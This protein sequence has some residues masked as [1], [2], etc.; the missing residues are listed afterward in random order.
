[1]WG[2]QIYHFMGA[3]EK[4]RQN[5]NK[6]FGTDI[7]MT[8]ESASVPIREITTQEIGSGMQEIGDGTAFLGF[9]IASFAPQIGL[10]LTAIGESLST[11]GAAIEIGSD[12]RR[13]IRRVI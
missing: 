1:M 11:L 7:P 13:W 3:M 2:L 9:G 6:T 10:P 4:S 12:V 8:V 5:F